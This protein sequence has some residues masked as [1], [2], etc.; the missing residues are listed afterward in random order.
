MPPL[1]NHVYLFHIATDQ[2]DT[3]LCFEE[4][5]GGEH[6]AGGGAICLGLHE[7]D[8]WPSDSRDHLTRAGCGWVATVIEAQV[9][10]DT[11]AI[12]AAIL[13]RHAAI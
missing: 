8:G 1:G 12:V 7:L 5:V 10:D 3:P 11:A 6:A 4:V 13:P 9:D 2:P